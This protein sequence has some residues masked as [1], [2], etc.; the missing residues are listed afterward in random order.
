MT[1]TRHYTTMLA[2][3]RKAQIRAIKA[4]NKKMAEIWAKN[5]AKCKARLKELGG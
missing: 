1:D 2:T 3:F 4:G 5:I